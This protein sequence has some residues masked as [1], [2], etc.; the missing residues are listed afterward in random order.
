MDAG[1]PAQILIIVILLPSLLTIQD[2]L[3]QAEND[4]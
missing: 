1:L 3:V 4:I 2:D